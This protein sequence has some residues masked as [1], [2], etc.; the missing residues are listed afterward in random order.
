MCSGRQIIDERLYVHFVTI[1]NLLW[2]AQR[3]KKRCQTPNPINLPPQHCWT[4][5]QWHTCDYSKIQKHISTKFT[6]NAKTKRDW[7]ATPVQ[8][9]VLPSWNNLHKSLVA[10]HTGSRTGATQ[11]HR[12]TGSKTGAT[13]PHRHT[14]SRTGAT[15][16]WRSYIGLTFSAQGP[17]G[18]R[19]SV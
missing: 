8:E 11:P 1:R 12:H 3:C 17:F 14:G 18:P 4:S 9:P 6:K 15:R 2:Q 19:P 10:G 13:Q 7:Q 16:H 5:Q